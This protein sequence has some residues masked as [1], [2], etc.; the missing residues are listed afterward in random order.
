MLFFPSVDMYAIIFY[1]ME[2][3]RSKFVFFAFKPFAIVIFFNT[4]CTQRHGIQTNHRLKKK[5]KKSASLIITPMAGWSDSTRYYRISDAV[6]VWPH[7][8]AVPCWKYE[9]TLFGSFTNT[10]LPSGIFMQRSVTVRT[11]PHPLARDTFN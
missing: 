5:K 7:Q 3:S 9:R 6:Q 4:E 8:I 1:T 11:M 2:P 10:Y